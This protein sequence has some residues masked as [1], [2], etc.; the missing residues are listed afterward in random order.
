LLHA[1]GKPEWRM[2]ALMMSV[3]GTTF[4]AAIQQL[5]AVKMIDLSFS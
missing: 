3:T 5:F 4:P 1:L 2:R